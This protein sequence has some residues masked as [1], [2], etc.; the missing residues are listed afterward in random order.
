MTLEKYA[1][2]AGAALSLLS[3]SN[4]THLD[5]SEEPSSQVSVNGGLAQKG[6]GAAICSKAVL[7]NEGLECLWEGTQDVDGEHFPLTRGLYPHSYSFSRLM[8]GFRQFY[9]IPAVAAG[10]GFAFTYTS[11]RQLLSAIPFC[12]IVKTE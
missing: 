8:I 9:K 5:K 3:S 4:S 6:E 1:S 11:E 10:Q 12:S 2:T 7:V